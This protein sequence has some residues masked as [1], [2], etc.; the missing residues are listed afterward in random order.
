MKIIYKRCS[1]N[2]ERQSVDRQLFG[3]EADKVFI[4]YASGK[5]EEDRPVFQEMLASLEKGDEVFFQ[6]LS[7]AGRNTVQLL[8]T[9]NKLVAKGITVNF[10]TESLTFTGDEDADPMK[11]AISEMMLTMLSS[12]NQMF[13]AQT[14]SAVKQ[15]LR[16]VKATAPEK[17]AKGPSSKWATTF[18]KNKAL[19]KHK[20]TRNTEASRKAKEPVARKIKQ[21]IKYS[22]DRLNL[23]Q[24]TEYLNKEGYRT[25]RN[26]LW[27]EANTSRLIKE[28]NIDYKKKSLKA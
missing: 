5:N 16:K 10:K 8:V 19:G 28:F 17:L 1:T 21:I 24:I 3:M 11:K 4:E 13:L 2:E 20:S 22:E 9:V 14:K 26:L 6:D 25:P 15:G 12:V 7:R 27:S 18:H 23:A